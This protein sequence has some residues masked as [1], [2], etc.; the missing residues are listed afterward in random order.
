MIGVQ[1]GKNFGIVTLGEILL[2]LSPPENERLAYSDIFEKRIGGSELNVAAGVSM[3]GIPSAMISVLPQNEMGRFARRSLKGAGVDDS[4]VTKDALPTSRLGLY[5]TE[6]GSYPRQTSVT[7]DR[8]ATSFCTLDAS[9]V[10]EHIFSETAVFHTSGITLAKD[11]AIRCAVKS[12]MEKFKA[13][14]ALVAF[15]VNYRASLWSEDAA[16]SALF[17]IL[18]LVDILFVSEET[19][20]RMLGKSGEL[21]KIQKEI[22]KEYPEI[23]LIASTKRQV[24]SPKIHDFSSLI[25]DKHSGEFHEESPYLGIE[26]VDRIG[27]GDAFVA[28][29]LFA[30]LKFGTA[31]AMVKYG[32]A[33]AALKITTHGDMPECDLADVERTI[34]NH[35]AKSTDELLR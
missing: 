25:Y 19:C 35:S 9:L 5:Y 13:A 26:V 11:Q 21:P 20:R 15:D 22:S 4:L 6:Q 31:E 14:G 17:E 32:N 10:P 23:S 3:L 27:S 7:Y 30:L 34:K 2:R 1:K 29:A 33:M 8:L 24:K 16:R 12:L 28:G 18:P